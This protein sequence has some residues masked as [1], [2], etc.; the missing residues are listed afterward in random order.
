LT[1]KNFLETF[2]NKTN[3][4][5]LVLKSQITGTS[6]LDR[7]AVLARI[8]NI[9]KTIPGNLPNIYLLHGDIDQDDMNNLYNHPKIK[10]LVSLTKGE[11]FGRPLLEFSFVNKPII[12]TLWSGHLDF[13]DKQFT[14]FIGGELKQVDQSA[15]VKK[16]ILKESQWFAPNPVEVRK[17]LKQV[18]N[19][20]KDWTVKGKKQGFQNKQT[21]NIDK[22]GQ[23]LEEILDQNLPDFPEQKELQL[24]ELKL[25]K[26]EKIQ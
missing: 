6:I 19:K 22:M 11:G 21:F 18:Y 10:A 24:P 13:L 12:T 9:R 20:Y 5:A 8:E 25:P 4:P 3:K 14:K 1:V 15:V 17:A 2:R 7:D 26:L 16:M 23:Q